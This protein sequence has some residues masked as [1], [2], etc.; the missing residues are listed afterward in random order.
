MG[1]KGFGEIYD[2]GVLKVDRKQSLDGRL[3][4]FAISGVIFGM[5][6]PGGTFMVAAIACIR[7]RSSPDILPIISAAACCICGVM[8]GIPAG[9]PPI[10][11]MPPEATAR[12]ISSVLMVSN[13]AAAARAISGVTWEGRGRF[14]S[15]RRLR[16][17]QAM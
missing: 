1:W 8:A 15:P 17:I 11:G 2:W 13:W 7:A 5:P 12:L 9:I 16:D 3:T 14:M 6:P 4:M 10:E